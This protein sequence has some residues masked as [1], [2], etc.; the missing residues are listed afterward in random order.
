MV[1]KIFALPF[2]LV[3]SVGV[4][5]SHVVSCHSNLILCLGRRA[6]FR[7]LYPTIY[8]GLNFS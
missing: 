1:C 2:R 8:E 3:R 5:F 4:L 6:R 7:D